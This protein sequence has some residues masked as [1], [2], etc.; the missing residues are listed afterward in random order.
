MPD[1]N[2]Y[3]WKFDGDGDSGGPLFIIQDGKPYLIS[4]LTGG[5]YLDNA[6]INCEFPCT[7]IENMSV[8]YWAD[9][10]PVYW[11]MPF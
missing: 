5:T 7:Q 9:S 6:G 10:T 1:G 2:G 3:S 8:Q 11:I 4:T